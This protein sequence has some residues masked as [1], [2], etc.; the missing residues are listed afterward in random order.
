MQAGYITLNS[1]KLI[2]E[3]ATCVRTTKTPNIHMKSYKCSSKVEEE[4]KRVAS[5]KDRGHLLALVKGV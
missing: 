2:K 4:V 1:I 5:N 3:L